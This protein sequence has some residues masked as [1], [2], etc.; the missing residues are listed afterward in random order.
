M[1]KNYKIDLSSYIPTNTS[2]ILGDKLDKLPLEEYDAL[3][4]L[5][6]YTW[7]KEDS[8]ILEFFTDGNVVYEDSDFSTDGLGHTVCAEDYFRNKKVKLQI[9]NFRYEVIY[10]V[11]AE[12]QTL[13]KFNIKS[14]TLCEGTYKCCLQLFDDTS[15]LDLVMFDDCVLYIR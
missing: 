14:N 3:G 13:I 15:S 11:E 1:F 5:I 6:G 4:R 9:I 2:T 8:I 7:N 12:A 10:E